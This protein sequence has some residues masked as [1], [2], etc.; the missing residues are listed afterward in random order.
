MD[1]ILLDKTNEIEQVIFSAYKVKSIAY[2][3]LYHLH[4]KLNHLHTV[5][6]SAVVPPGFYCDHSGPGLLSLQQLLSKTVM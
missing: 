4:I 5:I 6:S 1:L 3:Q 2:V